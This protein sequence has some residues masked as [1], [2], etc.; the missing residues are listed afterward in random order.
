[1]NKSLYI[2]QNALLLF[3]F[4]LL[5][6]FFKGPN[7]AYGSIAFLFIAMYHLFTDRRFSAKQIIDSGLMGLHLA[8]YL[9]LGSL[10][11]W[12]T[13][14][15]EEE[16]YYWIIYFLPIVTS[17]TN[18]SLFKTLTVCFLS[19]LLYLILIPVEIWSNPSKLADDLPE[20]LI[21]CTTFFIVGVVIHGFSQQN[22]QQLQQEK[23]LNA[24]LL[25]NHN[26]L[27]QSLTK[28]EAT[29]ETLRRKDRLAALGEMSARLAHEI[30]NP[31]GVIS[32][33]SQLL[34]SQLTDCSERQQQLLRVIREESSRLNSLVTD[35]LKFGRPAE[36]HCQRH[37]LD[38][39]V[40]RTVEQLV[41]VAQQAEVTLSYQPPP[42]SLVAIVD[43]NMIQQ[44]LLNLLLNGIDACDKGGQVSVKL[45][46]EKNSAKIIVCDNGRGIDQHVL[47]TIF[48]PF[49]TTKD[50]GT[51]LGLSTAHKIAEVHGGDIQVQSHVGHGSC[52]TVSLPI[53]EI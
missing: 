30:R 53:E 36:P 49:V 2:T 10:L 39:L 51:G 8:I 48:D 28:L 25:D 32:S 37:Q 17:A 4:V 31:L 44:L 45:S 9:L 20:F 13:T 46:G 11:I 29:E 7:L 16:S 26:A 22:R 1:M 3:L 18:L 52:F 41:A 12:V 21:F 27:Q 42:Q 6:I 33:S 23:Q 34:Q 43:S 15:E 50:H 35:F 38:L 24:L 14:G 19:S 5:L 40:Q 47:T